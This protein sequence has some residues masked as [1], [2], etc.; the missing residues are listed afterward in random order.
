MAPVSG[1]VNRLFRRGI[2]D[3]A[4]IIVEN[5]VVSADLYIIL[6]NGVNIRNTSRTVQK[7][8]TRA[9]TEMVG[10]DVAEVNIHIE[11]IAYEEEA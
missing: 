7:K 11:N 1:G 6:E 8:V 5:D 9:I 2:V 10:M 4:R 3:G